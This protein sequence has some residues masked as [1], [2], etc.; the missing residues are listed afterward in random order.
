[1]KKFIVIQPCRGITE[2]Y[3]EVEDIQIKQKPFIRSKGL[4]E[5]LKDKK[6]EKIKNAR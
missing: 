3:F 5:I 4:M 6:E 1:M 2:E